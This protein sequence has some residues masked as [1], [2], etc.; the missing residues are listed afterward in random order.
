MKYYSVKTFLYSSSRN[1]I[2]GKFHVQWKLT[3]VIKHVFGMLSAM[4]KIQNFNVE[5]TLFF[6][7]ENTSLFDV[8]NTSFLDV[9]N[10]SVFYVFKT[11]TSRPN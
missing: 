2:S 4:L 10:P 3:L 1:R 5:N 6:D 11:F 7:V 8:E 9:E